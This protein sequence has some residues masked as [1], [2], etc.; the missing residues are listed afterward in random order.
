MRQE[1]T[2]VNSQKTFAFL[3]IDQ[4]PE[5]E[6]VFIHLS[7]CSDEIE[8]LKKG[9]RFEFEPIESIKKPGSYVGKNLKFL[10]YS[11]HEFK[12]TSKIEKSKFEDK[13]KETQEVKS[14]SK[15]FLAV[16]S[17]SLI[18]GKKKLSIIQNVIDIVESGGAVLVLRA[19]ADNLGKGSPVH[20]HQRDKFVY[21]YLNK[22][23]AN[24]SIKKYEGKSIDFENKSHPLIS[25]LCGFAYL[26]SKDGISTHPKAENAIL[27]VVY[28]NLR[29]NAS[30]RWT[31]IGDETGQFNEFSG[32]SGNDGIT[33]TMVWM[34]IPPNVELPNLSPYFHGT[35]SKKG[36]LSALKSID[37]HSN[38]LIFSFTFEEGTLARGAGKIAKDPHLS[39]WNET[40]PLVLE[41]ISNRISEDAKVDIYSER[42]LELEPGMTLFE[43][44]IMDLKTALNDRSN[45]KK[46]NF[47]D[48]K[49]LAKSPCEHP[50]MGYPDAL[51]HVFNSKKR[52]KIGNFDLLERIE[53]RIIKS[54]FR[55]KSLNSRV[56]PSLKKSSSPLAFLKSLYDFPVDDIRDYVIP[57]FIPIVTNSLN[58]L[59]QRDWQRLLS[60]MKESSESG[61]HQNVSKI[62]HSLVNIDQELSK[63]SQDSTKFDFALAMLGTSNH[64][65]ARSQAEKCISI[66]N[67]LI[68][69]GFLPYKDRQ[70]KFKNLQGGNKDNQFEFSHIDQDISFPE[71]SDYD[72]EWA[73]YLGAQALSRALKG[74]E[75]DLAIEIEDYLLSKTSDFDQLERRYLMSAELK[76]EIGE[77]KQGLELL[78]EVLPRH[79]E[80]S[81]NE[82]IESNIYY[83]PS[84]LKGFVLNKKSRNVFQK[85]TSSITSKFNF[86]HPS[87]RTAYWC[88]RWSEQIGNL[89]NPV[90]IESRNYIIRLMEYPKFTHEAPGVIL[91]CELLDLVNRNLIEID[92]ENFLKKVLQNSVDSTNTWVSNNEPNEYDWLAPL[93]FNYR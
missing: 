15:K 58:S 27:D 16:R 71:D 50:W 39:M 68:E 36:V 34:A 57:F 19:K 32:K 82:L 85:Y 74:E 62:I 70:I 91:A 93:N 79:V 29:V 42:V 66:C 25:E 38:I 44:T 86:E 43:T 40:L 84:L 30:K 13:S 56:N 21:D 64:I 55:Q 1:G 47:V 8:L 51:G 5:L 73:R 2:V 90:S 6:N 80:K 77:I 45:W 9:M 75:L 65:G 10:G 89:N 18:R 31:I 28:G 20:S 60:F 7:D 22:L 53:N 52:K 24:Y 87:Q 49:I 63:L 33:S 54:P 37:K 61:S 41:S 17:Q 4:Q 46:L 76:F 3:R 35:T 11:E 59:N 48:M 12:N 92:A 26:L 67:S 23:F 14:V 81:V 69:E 78:E 88:T 72:E 83:L